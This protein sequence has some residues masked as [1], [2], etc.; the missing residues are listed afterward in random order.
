MT[1]EL[2]LVNLIASDKNFLSLQ[3]SILEE[4]GWTVL[5]YQST[6]D[7][8]LSLNWKRPGCAISLVERSD[9]NPWNLSLILKD[10][11]IIYPVIYISTIASI[12]WAVDAMK[13]GASS[14]LPY[15]VQKERL[16][17]VVKEAIEEN[18]LHMDKQSLLKKACDQIKLLTKTEKLVLESF[19]RGRTRKEVADLLGMAEKTVAHH[20][21]I[22]F[23]KLN[24][25]K[26]VQA[27][28]LLWL[29]KNK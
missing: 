21:L 6:D 8:I 14:F 24:T 19:S 17:D 29:S 20:C 2:P 3:S 1:T 13:N 25:Q 28:R 22:I 27:V 9:F 10:K 11:G 23:K 26:M 12:Y 18:K 15:P 16:L 4:A 5:V 7:F